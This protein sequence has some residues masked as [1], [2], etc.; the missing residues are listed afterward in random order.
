V[1]QRV[2]LVDAVFAAKPM[3]PAVRLVGNAFKPILEAGVVEELLQ[4]LGTRLVVEIADDREEL[5]VEGVAGGARRRPANSRW[6]TT[7][8][9]DW[10]AAGVG[11]SRT[12]S[13][14]DKPY[15]SGSQLYPRMTPLRSWWEFEPSALTSHRPPRPE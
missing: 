6:E 10:S 14:S 8:L 2:D 12:S 4:R 11:S 5:C 13:A 7:G 1:Q 9:S 3:R 15:G